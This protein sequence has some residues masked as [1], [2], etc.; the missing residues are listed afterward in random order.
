MPFSI[1]PTIRSPKEVDWSPVCVCIQEKA[2]LA[3]IPSPLLSIITTFLYVPIQV[4]KA[5][6][7]VV[8]PQVQAGPPDPQE[9][10]A[11]P[12][13][14]ASPPLPCLVFTDIDQPEQA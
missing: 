12:S 4:L 13:A 7:N 8:V 9:P 14:P 5:L 11:G 10:L 1:D 2:V 3:F 6:F